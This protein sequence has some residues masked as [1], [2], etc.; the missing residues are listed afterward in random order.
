MHECTFMKLEFIMKHRAGFCF[1]GGLCGGLPAAAGNPM[2][3][4]AMTLP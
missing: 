2:A 1:S 3:A 4:N